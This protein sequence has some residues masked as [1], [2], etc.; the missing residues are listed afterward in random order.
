MFFLTEFSIAAKLLM[1]SILVFKKK[2]YRGLSNQ[3]NLESGVQRSLVWLP[4]IG[5]HRCTPGPFITSKEFGVFR[6]ISSVSGT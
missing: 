1:D 6:L 4:N 3:K 2:K 5:D